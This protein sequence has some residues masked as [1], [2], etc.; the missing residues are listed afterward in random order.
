MQLVA[1]V[2]RGR[3]LHSRLPTAFGRHFQLHRLHVGALSPV[4]LALDALYS[5]QDLL[6]VLTYFDELD[7]ELVDISAQ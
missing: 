7:V 3:W 5:R 6:D 4:G 2:R 1:A